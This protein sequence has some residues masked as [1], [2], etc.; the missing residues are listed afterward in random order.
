MDD[1]FYFAESMTVIRTPI[2]HICKVTFRYLKIAWYI[3]QSFSFLSGSLKTKVKLP[4][5]LLTG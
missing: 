4:L 2:N 5:D 1:P 3:N